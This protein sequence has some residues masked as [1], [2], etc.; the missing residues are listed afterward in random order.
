MSALVS[1][2]VTP[3]NKGRGLYSAELGGSRSTGYTEQGR[4][5]IAV[6][7]QR[8]PMIGAGGRYAYNSFRR[9]QPQIFALAISVINKHVAQVNVKLA[10]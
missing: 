10:T 3:R 9:Q 2:R 7:N 8:Q 6:L 4:N 5:M 1:F